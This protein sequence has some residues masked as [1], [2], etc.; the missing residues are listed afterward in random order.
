MPA[1]K[2]PNDTTSSSIKGYFG[3]VATLALLIILLVLIYPAF[4]H[5]AKLNKEL[6][7]ARTVKASLE[8][9]L[10]NLETAKGNLEEVKDSL[11]VL[12]LALPVGSDIA[13]Y[14]KKIESLAAK[15]QLGITAVQF[16]DVPLS[17][18]NREKSLKTKHLDYTIT[19]GGSFTNFVAFLTDVEKFIRT[20]DVAAASLVKGQDGNL[21]ESLNITSYYLGIDFSSNQ[22]GK[23]TSVGVPSE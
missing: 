10:T 3:P 16:S 9:K 8:T 2:Q 19:V 7:D 12:D 22:A 21:S 23:N 18:P 5:V 1:T 13:P 14:L 11:S 15:N 20:S 4:K 6:S 17:K